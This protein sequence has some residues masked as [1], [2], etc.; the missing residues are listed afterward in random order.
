MVLVIDGVLEG[1]GFNTG[2]ISSQDY[3]MEKLKEKYGE[4]TAFT[5]LKIQNRLGASFDA[6]TAEWSFDNLIVKFNSAEGQITSG[7]INID[8]PKGKKWRED[9]LNEIFK[10]NRSL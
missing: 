9:K 1:L 7:L 10:N 2:G 6:V 3:V 5:P 4:P 8:S